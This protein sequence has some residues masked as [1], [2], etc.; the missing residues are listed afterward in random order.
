VFTI[1]FN[2]DTIVKFKARI[3]IAGWGLHRDVDYIESYT[4]TAPIGD[5]YLLEQ[6]ALLLDLYV[7]E[8]D[9]EQ[10][11]CQSLMPPTPSGE[12]VI[13]HLTEGTRVYESQTGLPM[14]AKLIM[15]LYG[16]PAAG[17]ALA[18]TLHDK[19]LNRTSGTLCPVPLV[20]SETQPVIFAANFPP[21]HEM[22]KEKFWVWINNDN[23]RCY[24]SN[25][26]IYMLFREWLATVFQITGS[27]VPLN[28]QSPQTC[29]GVTLEYNTNSVKLSMDG[30][31]QLALARAGLSNCNPVSTPMTEGFQLSKAD[32]PT[33]DS[34]RQAVIDKINIAF[35]PAL[36]ERNNGPIT[37]YKELINFYGS[38]VST[39]GWISKQI[40]PIISVAHSILS[41]AMHC[42]SIA[43]FMACKRVYRFLA[44]HPHMGIVYSTSKRYNWRAGIYPSYYL[45]AD[46]AF[47]SDAADA[48]TQGG[49]IGGLE[50][51]AVS[52]WSTI[53]SKRVVTSTMHAETY[54]GS[55][56][57]RHA[58]YIQQ[59]MNFLGTN[60]GEPI[61]LALDNSSTVL[62]T[63]GPIRK[64]SPATRHFTMDDRFIVQCVEDGTIVV[65]HVPGAPQQMPPSGNDGFAVDALTKPLGA[66]LLL[67]YY[68]FLHGTPA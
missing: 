11:Y 25:K 59:L 24:S 22:Y 21:G 63:A 65:R 67:H 4:G 28:E 16:H 40:G 34:Q 39:L 27:G 12:P 3:C 15:A 23:I 42:P 6:Y 53:K 68:Q 8:D 44:G 2:N 45:M 62:S 30:Y 29:L 55:R 31:I 17:F 5:L 26:A 47:I 14:Q 7:F 1:K 46:S 32:G 49:Y 43:S 33:T 48:K 38:L 61:N 20:Q 58:C 54:H 10:A 60:T 36:N 57:C 35:A 41:R 51:L 64:F 18:R 66:I 13:M 19:L 50:G 56:A 37:N 9:L 52:H